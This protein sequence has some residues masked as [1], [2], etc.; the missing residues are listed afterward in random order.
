MIDPS[1]AL[2][3]VNLSVGADCVKRYSVPGKWKR[4]QCGYVKL[5]RIDQTCPGDFIEIPE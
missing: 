2:P 5:G 1:V 4:D 3:G